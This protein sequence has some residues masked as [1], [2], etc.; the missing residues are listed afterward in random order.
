MKKIILLI[1]FFLTYSSSYSQLDTI[2]IN[3]TFDTSQNIYTYTPSQSIYGIRINGSVVLND[4]YSLVRVI[5]VKSDSTELLI[6]EA[7][8]WLYNKDTISFS[9]LLG[10]SSPPLCGA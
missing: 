9:N 7:Y 4:Y 5:L 3:N 10:V 1:S 6:Y 8:P 2:D